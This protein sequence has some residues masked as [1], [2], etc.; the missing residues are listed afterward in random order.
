MLKAR[1]SRLYA[2][3]FVSTVAM[4]CLPGCDKKS[5]LEQVADFGMRQCTGVAVS[6]E[7]RVFVSFPRWSLGHDLSVAEVLPDGSY[8]PYPDQE[9]NRWTE[10]DDPRQRFV[11]VQSVYID[12]SDPGGSLWV[13]DSGK[14][15]LEG[16]VPNAA[17]LVLIDLSSNQIERSV[18]FSS[19][20]APK[21]SYLNDVRVDARKGFAYITDSGLGAII[22]VNL[23]TSRSRRVLAGH[24]STKAEPGVAPVIGGMP[25]TLADGSVPQVHADGLALSP[26]KETLYFRAL[27]AKRLYR[28]PTSGLRN[29][30]MPDS[31]ID[32]S[33]ALVGPVPVGGGMVVS[34]RGTLFMTAVESNAIV[35][36]DNAGQIQVV[37]GGPEL[38]WPGSIAIS[39]EGD[40]YVTRSQIHLAPIFNKGVSKV[41]SPHVLYRAKAVAPPAQSDSGLLDKL[42]VDG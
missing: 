19:T 39:S 1:Q 7:K 2:I 12:T 16:V 28:I 3:F 9:T 29:F 22:V 31:K 37:A 5:P 18:R 34:H 15:R 41:V 4:L 20:I 36:R 14:P 10:G 33:V 24:A 21:D 26:N 27:T 25:W 40:L 32:E 35:H 17:K 38:S 13:L 30:S 11:S 8:R 42:T 6:S 23:N